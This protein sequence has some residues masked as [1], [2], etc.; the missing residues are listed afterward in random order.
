M[1]STSRHENRCLLTESSRG[2]NI[3]DASRRINGA[4]QTTLPNGIRI[5]GDDDEVG[6][7]SKVVMS[8]DVWTDHGGFV[9][10]PIER[11]IRIPLI[12]G[13]KK[14]IIAMK[15]GRKYNVGA[16]DREVINE[17]HNKMHS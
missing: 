12:E 5:Y 16:R 13:W 15:L 6:R 17:Y 1:R 3:N 8:Y 11:W 2:K 10:I 7:L 14:E 4:T 9:D